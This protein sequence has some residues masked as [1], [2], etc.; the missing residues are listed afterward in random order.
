MNKV[1]IIAPLIGLIIFG[2]FY[3]RFTSKYDEDVKAQVAKVEQEK[4]DRAARDIKNR[5]ARANPEAID[6]YRNMAELAR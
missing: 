2:S 1:Y 5:E 4:K 6:I 3:Y